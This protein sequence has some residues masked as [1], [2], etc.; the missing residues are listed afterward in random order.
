MTVFYSPHF[1]DETP[2]TTTLAVAAADPA[3]KS[4]PGTAHATM[5]KTHTLI[6]LAGATLADEDDIRMFP[7]K[8]GDRLY[9]LFISVPAAWDFT[10]LTAQIGLWE[11]GEVHNGVV[12]D[13]DLFNTSFD[14]TATTARVDQFDGNVL[15]DEDRGKRLWEMANEGDGTYTVD[16]F[17]VWDIV[18]TISALTAGNAVSA[19]IL[20]EAFYTSAGA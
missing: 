5:K 4:A 9:E 18:I 13:D 3:I 12:I 16:P 2:T 1:T 10:T 17:E 6:N 20:L 19:E 15:E 7:M 8:S 11:A 14:L